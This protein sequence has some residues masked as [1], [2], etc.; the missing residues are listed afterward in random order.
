[1]FVTDHKKISETEIVQILLVTAQHMKHLEPL[2]YQMCWAL[3]LLFPLQETL[4]SI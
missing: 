4:P 2:H 1:M 3:T